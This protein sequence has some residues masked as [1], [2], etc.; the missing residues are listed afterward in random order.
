MIFKDK[1][2]DEKKS[3][4]RFRKSKKKVEMRHISQRKVNLYFLSFFVGLIAICALTVIISFVRVTKPVKDVTSNQQVVQ[5]KP[6]KVD[7]RLQEFLS[8]YIEAYFN[9]SSDY[10]D[11]Q[12]R[13]EKLMGYY[14]QVP[15]VKGESKNSK[16]MVLISYKPV[17]IDNGL[18]TYRVTYEVGS[19]DEK[20]RVTVLFGIPF[21]G[22]NGYYFV[23]G[24]PHFK[25]MEDYK[26]DDSSNAKLDLNKTDKFDE[27]K[28][29]KLNQFLDLFFKN[30][31]TSQENLDVIAE[32]VLAITGVSYKKVN[33][34]FYKEEGNT[35]KAYVQVA[36]S[37]LDVEHSE[38]MTL[39]IVERDGNYFVTN[40]EY[41]IPSDYYK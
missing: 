26:L 25:A 35:I 32:N 16:E 36:F 5:E 41:V 3:L 7:N 1:G 14:N 2:R 4:L 40:V 34:V 31:T 17:T 28:K 22:G 12:K 9:V 13:E 11:Q 18:A 10:S 23:S 39:T 33:Y 8:G 27:T 37:I 6:E 38:N 21:E 20:N 24:L 15:E 29:E 19:G 30:Y